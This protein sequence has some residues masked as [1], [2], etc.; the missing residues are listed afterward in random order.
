MEEFARRGDARYENDVLP[1]LYAEDKVKFVAFE[2]ESG[3]YEIDADE[4]EAGNQLRAR[5]PG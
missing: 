2:I 1:H 3:A 4:R 5:N